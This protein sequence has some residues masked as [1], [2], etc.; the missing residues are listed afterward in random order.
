[1]PTVAEVVRRYGPVYLERFGATIPA[2]HEGAARHRRLPDRRL[3][4]VLYRC[5]DCGRMHALG[6]SCGNRHCP[7]CIATRP[8]PGSRTTPIACCRARTS[9]SPF[10]AVGACVVVRRAP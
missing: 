10:P 1:M 9:W 2:A 8:K 4:T 3:G 7:S 5:E 6:R